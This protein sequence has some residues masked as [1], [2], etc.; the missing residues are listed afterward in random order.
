[1]GDYRTTKHLAET[2]DVSERTAYRIVKLMRENKKRYGMYASLGEVHSVGA[3]ADCLKWHNEMSKG[4][5]VPPFDELES[6]RYVRTI[7]N[8]GRVVYEDQD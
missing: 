2:F 1:M 5:K 6:E 3:F 8:K 7:V 4:V